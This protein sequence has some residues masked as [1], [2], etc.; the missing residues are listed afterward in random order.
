MR[1][2]KRNHNRSLFLMLI[3]SMG[4]SGTGVAY[5]RWSGIQT[6]TGKL[7]TG[8]LDFR[9][10]QEEACSLL[11]VDVDGTEYQSLKVVNAIVENEGKSIDVFVDVP[12]PAD[13]FLEDPD[14]LIKLECPLEQGKSN[15]IDRVEGQEADFQQTSQETLTLVPVSAV[16]MT[17]QEGEIC[18]LPDEMASSFA[19]PLEFEVFRETEERDGGLFGIVYLRLMDESRELMAGFPVELDLEEEGLTEGL[20]SF[21]GA[22]EGESISLSLDAQIAVTYQCAIPFYVEQGH[23]QVIALPEERME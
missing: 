5:A 23:G 13:L 15:T 6:M 16:L 11:I 17:G 9:H 3:L 22:E 14:R 4:L 1:R 18:E 20:L 10:S 21:A 7:T 2:K 12:I 8:L 19:V